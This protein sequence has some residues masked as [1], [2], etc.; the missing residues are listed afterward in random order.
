VFNDQTEVCENCGVQKIFENQQPVDRH[1]YYFINKKGERRCTELIVTPIKDKEGNIIAALELAVDVTEKRRLESQHSTKLERLVEARTKQ[2]KETQEKLVNTE[3]LAAIGQLAAMVGHDLRNP[4]TGMKAATYYLKSKIRSELNP[5]TKEM[6]DLI[7]NCID[8]SNKIVNDLLEYSRNVK[9]E[10]TENSPAIFITYAFSTIKV[11]KNIKVTHHATDNAPVKFDS[12]KM[13]RVF[14]NIIK[15]AFDAMPKG[16]NLT[17]VSKQTSKNWVV[18]FT[19]SGEGM[20]E[21]TLKKLGDPLFTTKAKGMGFGIPICK[22]IVEAHGGKLL[23]DST[24]GQGTTVTVKIPL[25]IE[26]AQ[27][28]QM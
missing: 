26:P 22:R 12:A 16:G 27:P 23:I 1:D 17:I 15:N 20:A 28:N 13:L 6:L 18:S 10:L 19:D 5:K 4:L 2:L 21:E 24:L 14:L 9:V 8:Q 3:R 11:P 7:D 25:N